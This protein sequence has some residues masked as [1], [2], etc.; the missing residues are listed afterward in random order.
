MKGNRVA[1]FEA[2]DIVTNKKMNRRQERE[3]A[4]QAYLAT[5][6]QEMDASSS[7]A[8]LASSSDE[9]C[10]RSPVLVEN[11]GIRKGKKTGTNAFI[12]SDILSRPSLVR[13]STRLKI[14][15]MELA[16]FTRCL[17]KESGHNCAKGSTSYATADRVR[18]D[19]LETISD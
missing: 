14:T 3:A 13:L 17:I 16:A 2:F 5:Q 8:E 19:T 1:T 7:V 4:K 10:S 9:S 18:R 15:P 12:Q 6:L 11:T